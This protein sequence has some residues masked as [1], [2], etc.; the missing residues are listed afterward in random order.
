MQA[1]IARCM[2]NLTKPR[3]RDVVL[4][5]FCGAGAML[6]EAGLIGCRVVGFDVQRRMVRG[7]LRNLG[8]YGVRPVGIC[9]A[10]AKNL[11]IKKVD[12][13]VTDP[14]YGISATTKGQETKQIVADFLL[15]AANCIKKYDRI[16]I[17]SPKS[18]QVGKLG[19]QIGFKHVESHFVYVHRSLTRE[20][21]VLE[22]I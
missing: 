16:C 15:E 21:T 12:C 20:I 14:P 11:P 19:E 8:N 2:V 6:I 18:V 10:D 3:E 17:G 22:Q 4:D 13:I 1:K 7:S 5:P 9:V